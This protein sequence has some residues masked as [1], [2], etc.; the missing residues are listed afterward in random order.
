MGKR[1]GFTWQ[2]PEAWGTI[3]QLVA[4][5]WK[6]MKIVP[7][8]LCTDAEFIRRVYL[9]LTGLPPT[10]DKVRAFLADSRDTRRKRDE[11]IDRLIGSDD[12]V[13]YWTNKWADLMQV[14]R[15][16]LGTPGAAALRGWIRGHVAENTPYD[17]FVSQIITATGS[18]RANPAASY[19]K[20]L[21]DPLD[22]M[23]NTTHLFLGRTLQLQQVSRPSVRTVDTRS[24]L[25]NGRVFRPVPACSRSGGERKYRRHGGRK[26]K[27]LV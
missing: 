12:Y 13:D 9:D 10:A 6:R 14:N 24:V 2:E 18:N 3:D 22:T 5:K 15:K 17:Q 27:A 19:Y 8:G 11:L 26:G 16:F 1:D 25:S 20:I 4:S 7:S 23:E 21:R